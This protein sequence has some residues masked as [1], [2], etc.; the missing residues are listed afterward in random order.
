MNFHQSKKIMNETV[1]I[2]VTNSEIVANQSAMNTP[3]IL[4][5]IVLFLSCLFDFVCFATVENTQFSFSFNFFFF[6]YMSSI[7]VVATQV[8]A[9]GI[10]HQHERLFIITLSIS[11]CSINRKRKFAARQMAIFCT[12]E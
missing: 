6:T 8:N 10:Q 2:T 1:A 5:I 12:N 7:Q 3:H 4:Y 9:N 11:C